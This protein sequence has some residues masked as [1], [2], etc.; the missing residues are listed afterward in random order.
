MVKKRVKSVEPVGQVDAKQTEMRLTPRDALRAPEPEGGEGKID[1]SVYLAGLKNP[2][3]IP[4]DSSNEHAWGTLILPHLERLGWVYSISICNGQRS[5]RGVTHPDHVADME[6][7]FD[8]LLAAMKHTAD[9]YDRSGL[10]QLASNYRDLIAKIEWMKAYQDP[11][12]DRRIHVTRF[13]LPSSALLRLQE[14]LS[15][16]STD[17]PS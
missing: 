11:G 6:R 14:K 7:I 15:Q 8:W 17:V 10:R 13:Y 12:V 9:A 5:I 1:D 2:C 16:I 3:Q 4:I